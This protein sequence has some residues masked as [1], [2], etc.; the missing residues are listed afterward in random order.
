MEK[1]PKI[2]YLLTLSTMQA[3]TEGTIFSFSK[4]VVSLA[5]PFTQLQADS[6]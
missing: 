2:L 3:E 6:V 4:L 1:P 5:P